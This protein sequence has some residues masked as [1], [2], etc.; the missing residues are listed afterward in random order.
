MEKDTLAWLRWVLVP[1][2]GIKRSH[3]LLAHM[4]SPSSLFLHPDRWPLPDSIKT[5]LKQMSRLGEQHPVHRR[6][7]EQIAWRDQDPDHHHLVS[8][9]DTDY[10]ML[11]SEIHDAPILLWVKGSAELLSSP[12]IGIVGSRSASPNARNHAHSLAKSLCKYEKTVTS[13]GASGIDKACHEGALSVSGKTIAVFGCGIDQVYPKT[14]RALFDEISLNGAL[15]SEHPL[16]TLPKP[17]HF[18][19]RNRIISGLSD[20]IVVVEAAL[21][22]GSLVT[23][24]H[25]LEQGRD[26]YAMPGDVLNPNS[27]GCHQLIRDGAYLL[28]DAKD[29]IDFGREVSY[30]ENTT[31]PG[32]LS[33]VQLQ[34]ISL[35]KTSHLPIEGISH[36]LTIA[37]HQLLEPLLELELEG[38]IEQHPGGYVYSGFA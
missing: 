37:A 19:R 34:I 32:H 33:P 11:L 15:V 4:D 26:V 7:L 23:A 9:A 14:H 2:L 28:T 5:V 21:R 13:G 35:L 17:G 29:I 24:Q 3:D 1:G 22:S 31:L 8:I 18:P 16:G 25:A 36:E 10:P 6:A 20:A 12:Q 38:L 27:A 30:A